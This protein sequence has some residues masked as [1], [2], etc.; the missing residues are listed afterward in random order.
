ML[1]PDLLNILFD[2][3]DCCALITLSLLN[4]KKTNYANKYSLLRGYV[5]SI[6]H[7]TDELYFLT[8]AIKNRQTT[9]YKL[10]YISSKGGN[11]KAVK[12]FVNYVDR[13]YAGDMARDGNIE[14][15]KY[16]V[17]TGAYLSYGFERELK[18]SAM[19]GH[20]DVVKYL[21][22]IGAH[23]NDK[24]DAT[25][26]DA[27]ALAL[28]AGHGRLEVV[29]YLIGVGAVVDDS[30]YG[31][32]NCL[33]SDHIEVA[34]YLCHCDPRYKNF[35]LKMSVKLGILGMI[36]YLVDTGADV[37][38]GDELVECA[39]KGHI[40]IVKYFVEIGVNSNAKLNVALRESARK[41]HTSVV[42]YLISI[43]A[44][45]CV[46]DFECMVKQHRG[47]LDTDIAHCLMAQCLANAN[48]Q[49]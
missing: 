44:K 46:R 1:I 17:N 39:K 29:K 22:S 14:I 4:K 36:E 26:L 31:L 20:I 10:L 40:E 48:Y 45:I 16:L 49:V 8:N 24:Y 3:S 2:Q 25:K 21:V 35:A 6:K 19:N 30:C 23:I 34:K 38:K 43:G 41:G 11:L 18:Q 12:C 5:E 13:I 28:S 33:N 42:K 9:I 32:C 47:Y 15:V 37:S 7:A 27:T